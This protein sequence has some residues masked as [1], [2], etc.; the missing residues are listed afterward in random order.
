MMMMSYNLHVL[1]ARLHLM[2]STRKQ[3]KREQYYIDIMDRRVQV[4]P[5]PLEIPKIIVV[6]VASFFNVLLSVQEVTWLEIIT[7]HIT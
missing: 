2:K 4:I 3:G 6:K 5:A 7:M 1:S